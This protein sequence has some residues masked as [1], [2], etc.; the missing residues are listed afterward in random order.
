MFNGPW[1][2]IAMSGNL[3]VV[4][5]FNYLLRRMDIPLTTTSV[6]LNV[7]KTAQKAKAKAKVEPSQ[8]GGEV[9][10]ALFRKSNGA[11]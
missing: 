7:T 4:D 9:V 3:Y 1:G 11:F 2:V 6:T 5:S 10:V 8:A